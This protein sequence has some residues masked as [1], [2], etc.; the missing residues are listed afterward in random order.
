VRQLIDKEGRKMNLV[1]LDKKALLT[2]RQGLFPEID[3]KFRRQREGDTRLRPLRTSRKKESLSTTN[4][5]QIGERAAS[6]SQFE[7]V[8]PSD[9]PTRRF[10]QTSSTIVPELLGAGTDPLKRNQDFARLAGDAKNLMRATFMLPDT[11]EKRLPPTIDKFA[12]TL[13]CPIAAQRQNP[14]TCGR[15]GSNFLTVNSKRLRVIS[16][17]DGRLD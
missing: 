13:A 14:M 5:K 8:Q 9:S 4:L 17:F 2:S 1:D 3:E 10:K 16:N 6:V 15:I 7:K 11:I 12:R